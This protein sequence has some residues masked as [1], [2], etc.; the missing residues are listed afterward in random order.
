MR[1]GLL[2]SSYKDGGR[3]GLVL[4]LQNILLVTLKTPIST[5]SQILRYQGL[6]LEH[7]NLLEGVPNSALNS[8]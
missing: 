7:R 3:A 1:G 4:T 6:G 5:Y 8:L 2:I